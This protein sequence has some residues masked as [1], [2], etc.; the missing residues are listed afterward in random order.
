MINFHTTGRLTRDAKV[1]KNSDGTKARALFTVAHNENGSNGFERSDFYD[2]ILWGDKRV[3]NVAPWMLKGRLVEIQGYMETRRIN[4]ED[5]SFGHTEYR[6]RVDSLVF[7]DK[8]P[9]GVSVPQSGKSDKLKRLQ[10]MVAKN[11]EMAAA[12]AALGLELPKPEPELKVM[13]V[14]AELKDLLGAAKPSTDA[15]V[16]A[17]TEPTVDELLAGLKG[18]LT[19]ENPGP[20][21]NDGTPF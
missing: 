1:F 21:Q 10:E 9:E 3:A 15:T 14:M 2:C 11:P 13:D 4:K 5:G 17:T 20:A 18:A 7:L 6:V 8:K 16:P 19:E 12:M